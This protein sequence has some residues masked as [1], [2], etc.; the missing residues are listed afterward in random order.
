MTAYFPFF[1][2]EKILVTYISLISGYICIPHGGS[3]KP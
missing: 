3:D 1:K 2:V